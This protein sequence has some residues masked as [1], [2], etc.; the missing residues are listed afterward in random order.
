MAQRRQHA[1]FTIFG[2][3]IDRKPAVLFCVGIGLIILLSVAYNGI[4]FVPTAVQLDK[5]LEAP[6]QSS[7]ENKSKKNSSQN[8]SV[9]SAPLKRFLVDVSGAVAKPGVYKLSADDARVMDAIEAAGGLSDDADRARINL[10]QKVEDGEKVYVPREG[11]ELG[12][13]SQLDSKLSTRSSSGASQRGLVNINTA[14][15]TTLQS[16][17]GVGEATAKAII[18]E[19]EANGAFES[20]EDLMRVSGIGEKKFAKFKDDICV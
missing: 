17:S 20:P 5:K 3:R 4:R 18:K 19:R 7:R 6:K 16:L 2:Q 11:E 12:M 1:C 8:T 9:E 14:D 13:D 15:E 10:A